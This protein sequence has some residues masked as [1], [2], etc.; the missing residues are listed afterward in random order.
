MENKKSRH[1]EHNFVEV[2]QE[3]KPSTN[4]KVQ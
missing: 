1:I 4:S 2:D 3:I